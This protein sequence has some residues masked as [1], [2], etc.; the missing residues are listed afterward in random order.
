MPVEPNPYDRPDLTSLRKDQGDPLVMY[1][2]VRDSLN[3]G[4]GKVAAQVA[5][6]V[7]MLLG[8]YWRMALHAQRVR[9]TGLLDHG[10]EGAAGEE[11]YARET[12]KRTIT[13]EWLQSS[14]RKVVLRADDKEW[15]KL[16]ANHDG[17]LVRDAGLTE[18]EPGSET[19]FVL[20][21]MRK[22]SAPKLISRLRVL[23]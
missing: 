6:G 19:V 13:E 16:K 15:E 14:Y 5:H 20:W 4:A 23:Q 1:I 11:A 10:Y 22:S 3:M 18:V 12:A 17:F 21:P 8:C 9:A 2:I 7:G